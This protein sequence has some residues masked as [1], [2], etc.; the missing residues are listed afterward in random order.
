MY[1]VKSICLIC[2]RGCKRV[3]F[4]KKGSLTG[5]LR[6]N[7]IEKLRKNLAGQQ[8]IFV[9]CCEEAE[10]IVQA[11]YVVSKKVAEYSNSFSGGLGKNKFAEVNL[12]KRRV[13]RGRKLCSVFQH[14]VKAPIL[15]I[16]VIFIRAVC[17]RRYFLRNC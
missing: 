16:L 8:I 1:K 14:W 11:S 5:Q 3:Q 6:S 10:D 9:K 12:S 17:K 13:T 7:I 15:M 2:R 4:K